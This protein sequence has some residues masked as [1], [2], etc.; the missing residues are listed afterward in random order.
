[1][2][3]N[4][5]NSLVFF[6][7]ML[8][9][10]FMMLIVVFIYYITNKSVSKVLLDK[11]IQL[12]KES[13]KIASEIIKYNKDDY[14]NYLQSFVENQIKYSDGNIAY[15]I[16][17]DNQSNA[18][19]HSDKEKINKHYDD[20]YTKSVAKNGQIQYSKFYAD[21]QKIWTYDIMVPISIDGNHF[22]ALDIGIPISGINIIIES[23]VKFILLSSIIFLIILFVLSHK[24]IDLA[25]KPLYKTT[26]FINTQAKLD[27][28]NEKILNI[29]N[30]LQ[31][32]DVIGNIC[33]SL[34]TMNTNIQD[35]IIKTK[36]SSEKL[37]EKSQEFQQSSNEILNISKNVVKTVEEIANGANSQA[38]DAEHGA[39]SMNKISNTIQESFDILDELNQSTKNVIVAKDSGLNF[40]NNLVTNTKESKEAMIAVSEVINSNAENVSKIKDASDMIS[41][42]AAQTNLLALNAAIEA[43]RAGE[44]GRG[45]AIVADEIRK[46]AEDTQNFTSEIMDIVK[47]LIEKTDVAVDSIKNSEKLFITQLELVDKTFD[48]FGK[49]SDAIEVTE[50]RIRVLNKSFNNL[51]KEKQNMIDI[52][53]SLS[54]ISEEYAASTEQTSNSIQSQLETVEKISTSSFEL[55]KIAEEIQL[56]NSKFRV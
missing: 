16:V 19:A 46:L 12:A 15:C 51:N 20:D 24:F 52:V 50:N 8:I 14:V 47:K 4:F 35:F 28:S 45:F 55:S 9:A 49:I 25:L 26:D 48:N 37:F 5:K 10:L 23:I 7:M 41:S 13:S 3:K 43:A 38:K 56:L 44:H 33:T 22:G 53:E 39:E 17:I 36:N 32:N 42:I 27:F 1:M 31:R 2:K 29:E 40:I 54:A 11:N 18:I 34:K 21:V 30:Y 6:T